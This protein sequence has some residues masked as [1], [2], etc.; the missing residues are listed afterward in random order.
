MHPQGLLAGRLEFQVSSIAAGQTL[1]V[2]TGIK[3]LS[4]KIELDLIDARMLLSD[5]AYRQQTICLRL[6]TALE[7]SSEYPR[8]W[9]A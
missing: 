2:L 1:L 9:K 5:L 6:C 3:L 8:A 4:K 7:D